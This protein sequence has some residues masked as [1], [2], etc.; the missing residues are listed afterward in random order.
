MARGRL[1]ESEKKGRIDFY[2]VLSTISVLQ[3]VP[4]K[5]CTYISKHFV[6][7]TWVAVATG[8]GRTEN[9]TTAARGERRGKTMPTSGFAAWRER[10]E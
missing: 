1:F 10:L 3:Q 7:N 6:P 2:G 4:N 5:H 8:S 9:N